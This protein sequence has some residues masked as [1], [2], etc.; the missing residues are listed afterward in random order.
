MRSM[1]LP[2][3]GLGLALCLIG[4]PAVA[5]PGWSPPARVWDGPY[6]TPA[7]VVSPNGR[8]HLAARGETGIWVLTRHAGTWTR[9]R[10]TR[11][12]RDPDAEPRPVATW[13]HSPAIARDPVDGSLVV[14]YILLDEAG[15]TGGCNNDLAMR[16]RT[17]TGWS[18]ERR[19]ATHACPSAVSVAMRDGRIWIAVGER[20]LEYVNVELLTRI[21]GSWASELVSDR[22]SFPTGIGPGEPALAVGADGLP[23]LAYRVGSSI[24]FAIGTRPAGGLHKE[25]VRWG[26]SPFDGGAPALALTSRGDPRL[27]WTSSAGTWYAARDA[28]GDWAMDVVDDRH[29]DVALALER[30]GRP[31]LAIADGGLG[32]WHTW[33]SG[34]TWR[35]E[36]LAARSSPELGGI[37]I[38]RDGRGAVSFQ[39]GDTWEDATVWF[40]RSAG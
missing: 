5:T 34:G 21:G 16:V 1:R 15:G 25:L 29:V 12:V 36:R 27:A 35:T 6:A 30:G 39:H 31:H 20:D 10:L 9:E 8:V 7:M 22:S 19:V 11:D 14:V 26:S 2:G 3:L 38:D 33:R 24:R 13:A 40:T 23:R 32:V 4:T 17:G 28:D 18:P 37:G